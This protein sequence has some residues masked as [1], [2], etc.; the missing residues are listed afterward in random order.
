MT[1]NEIIKAL[2]CHKK[3]DLNTCE[4][5]PLLNIQGCAYKLS[6]NALDLINRQKD[7][8]E[9]L[10]VAQG[11]L[12]KYIAKLNK[13]LERATLQLEKVQKLRKQKNKWW[14]KNEN[15]SNTN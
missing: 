9:G 4:K 3:Q 5:C 1:E 14:V 7:E 12:Q 6:E 15:Q 13:E 8:I 11:T 10:I 2:E